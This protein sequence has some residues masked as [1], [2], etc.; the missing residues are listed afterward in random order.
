MISGILSY[1]PLLVGLLGDLPKTKCVYGCPVLSST[2]LCT[3]TANECAV[4]EQTKATIFNLHSI[5]IIITSDSRSF[6]SFRSLFRSLSPMIAVDY[7]D[8]G[9]ASSTLIE[10]VSKIDGLHSEEVNWL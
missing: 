6:L 1:N 5:S 2:V 10:F 8:A 4:R 9:D 3:R 7:A